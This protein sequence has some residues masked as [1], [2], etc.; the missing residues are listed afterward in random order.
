MNAGSPEDHVTLEYYDSDYPSSHF[1]RF[2]ENFDEITE[3]QG[4]ARDVER[5]REIA[6]ETGGPVLELGC[7]TGRVSI[8]LARDGLDVTGVD[9]FSSQLERLQGHLADESPGVRRRVVMRKADFTRLDL[10]RV[11]FKLV[12]CAFNTLLAVPDLEGQIDAFRCMRRHI[13]ADGLLAVDV[14]NPL[15]LSTEGSTK[16]RAFYTRRNVTTGRVYTRMAMFG[17]LDENQ[18]QRLHGWYDE[19]DDEGIVRR[20]H[21]SMHWRPIFRF[22][23][24]LM[25]R[26]AGF[27]VRTVEGGHHK[28]PFTARSPHIFV[29]ARP[30]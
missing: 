15:Q 25:M 6:R 16:P 13:A 11:S 2:Q 18:R 27:R 29:V 19:I 24:E 9:A 26:I 1:G 23:L 8:P 4:I 20:R 10:P 14:I 3:Q 30:V 7:G 5:Y 28:E 12:I 22:E 17:P 21:Y